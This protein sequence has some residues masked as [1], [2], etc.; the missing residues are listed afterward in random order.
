[1]S[2]NDVNINRSLIHRRLLEMLN[3][4]ITCYVNRKIIIYKG[5]ILGLNNIIILSVL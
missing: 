5:L 4:N 2:V 1:M 3:V